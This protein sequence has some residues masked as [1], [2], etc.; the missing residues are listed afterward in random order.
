MIDEFNPLQIR[1]FIQ[2][3]MSL[4]TAESPTTGAAAT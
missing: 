1:E 2:A 4:G 3:L